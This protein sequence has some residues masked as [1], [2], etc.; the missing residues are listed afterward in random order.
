MHPDDADFEARIAVLDAQLRAQWRREAR[1]H[2]GRMALVYAAYQALQ[3][4]GRGDRRWREFMAE[5][6]AEVQGG[7]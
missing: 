1:T 6:L 4:L 5:A 7:E 2:A 3:E